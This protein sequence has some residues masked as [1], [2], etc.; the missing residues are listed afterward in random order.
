MCPHPRAA[1]RHESCGDLYTLEAIVLPVDIGR[2]EV[3]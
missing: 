1:R 3:G 2:G